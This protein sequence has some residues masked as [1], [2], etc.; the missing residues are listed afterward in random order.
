MEG[1]NKDLKALGFKKVIFI[2]QRYNAKEFRGWIHDIDVHTQAW[3]RPSAP[4]QMRKC[5][6]RPGEETVF[7]FKSTDYPK[8][9]EQFSIVTNSIAKSENILSFRGRTV[10][11][12][13]DY[14]TRI[15][16]DC[17]NMFFRDRYEKPQNEEWTAWIATTKMNK[18]ALE[19]IEDL[20]RQ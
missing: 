19:K 1:T 16:I 6:S 2:Q 3:E 4:A 18:K 14:Y 7:C 11:P 5:S 9:F 20:C 15:E 17:S 12:T 10:T 13:E 8:N